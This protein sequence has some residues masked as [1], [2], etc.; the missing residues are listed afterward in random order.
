MTIYG[1]DA[2]HYDQVPNA[3][4]VVSEGFAFM[5]HKAGGDASDAELGAW[6][7]ATRSQRGKLLLGAYWVLYPGNPAGWA[8]AFLARLDSQCPGWRDGPFILQADCEKWNGDSSTVPGKADIRAFCDRL[9]SRVPKLNPIVYAPKWVYGDRLAG[10]GYPLW[11][12]S[13]VLGSG[14]ASHL[15]PGDSSSR[16]D[17]YSG[18]TP[19]ILQFT[20]SATIAGQTTC[21]AN[22]YRGTLAQLQDLVAP[23]WKAE[24]DVNLTDKYGDAAHPERDV[25]D[26][27]NDDAKLRDVL[28]GD[29]KGIAAAKLDPTSPLAKL[30]ALPAQVAALQAQVAAPTPVTIDYDALAQALVK[31]LPAELAGQLADVL[32]QRLSA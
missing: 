4:R 17:A 26:R 32:A 1:W 21:D 8:D 18:Q 6:W 14:S 31:A 16:W 20:S 7:A 10:L 15:Y 30:L 25:Q 29:V 27:L 9:S 28:W 13:Y 19:A 5:T 3:A 11:A 23:G 2:S 22:A 24:E 12:S